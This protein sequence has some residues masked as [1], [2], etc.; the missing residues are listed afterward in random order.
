MTG[1]AWRNVSVPIAELY[2][3]DDR[4][5]RRCKRRWI[6][7]SHRL[8]RII[9]GDVG[10]GCFVKRLGDIGHELIGAAASVIVVELLV[11]C[12]AGLAGEVWKFR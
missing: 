11:D 3:L 1:R 2:Q 5:R 9:G 6:W 7:I 8:A 4:I 10:D 12:S